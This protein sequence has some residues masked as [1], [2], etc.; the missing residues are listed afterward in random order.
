MTTLP[1][2]EPAWRAWAQLIRLPNLFTVWADAGVGVA[3][4]TAAGG[5]V[6]AGA[7]LL[8]AVASACF[9]AA[10]MIL[11]DVVDFAVDCA[12]RPDRPLPSGRIAWRTAAALAPSLLL[13]GIGLAVFAGWFA[14]SAAAVVASL[15]A[16]AIV[17]YDC[18]VKATGLGPL[19]MGLCRGLNVILASQAA[20]L[21]LRAVWF[22]AAI[23]TTYI[24][25][26]TWLARDE[27]GRPAR[28]TLAVGLA[29]LF[30][31]LLAVGLTP[32]LAP[33]R[34]ET[35][36]M[37]IFAVLGVGFLK[38]NVPKLHR[39]WHDLT[40]S[41]LRHAITQ[42]LRSLILLDTL[43]VLACVGWWGLLVL[44]LWPPVIWLGRHVYST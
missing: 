5:I 31:A 20:S 21:G 11:N 43:L 37:L 1:R 42:L 28:A 15:L 24:A 10:G 36:E 35:G 13:A 8:L 44:L 6:H 9:Y 2:A 23:L 29:A 17:C 32:W 3:A 14:G 7:M 40:P 30:V 19:N 38:F 26:V 34:L 22:P 33:R 12:E 39:A 27:A 16:L 18:G 25:G 4:V 41:A